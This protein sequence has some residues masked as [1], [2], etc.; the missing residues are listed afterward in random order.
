MGYIASIVNKKGEDTSDEM[1]MMLEVASKGDATSYGIANNM[2][3]ESFKECS[4]F[5]SISGHMLIGSKNLHLEEYP[6]EPLNQASH[7][8]VFKGIL[9]DSDNV[10]SLEVGNSIM[11]NPF[12]GVKEIISNREGAFSILVVTNDS[13]V[14]GLD[15]IGTIPLYY[16]ENSRSRAVATNKRMLWRIGIE[17]KPLHPGSILTL[18]KEGMKKSIVK[19][20]EYTPPS[21]IDE[22]TAIEGLDKALSETATQLT[23]KLRKGVVAFSGGVDSTII[24]QYLVWAGM[25]I[26]L[27][28]TGLEGQA[29]IDIAQKAAESLDLPIEVQTFTDHD[30]ENT[31]DDIIYSV[32]EPH[33]MKIGIAYP[34]HWTAKK[35]YTD[36]AGTVFSGNGADE[37]L[38]GYKRYHTSFINGEDVSKMIFTDVT[39]SWTN[40]F[41][42]DTK[43]CLDQGMRLILPFTHP[44][45]IN[46]GLSIH[47]SLNISTDEVCL[48]KL[49]LRKLAK[50]VGIP[51]EIADRPKK[52]AQYSTGVD[53][54]LR[55]LAKKIGFSTRELVMA[56]Y[57]DISRV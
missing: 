35:A 9:Y 55:R 29:E 21:I 15:H 45:V 49:V 1:L 30:V 47:P 53:K 17:P 40:N 7:S 51:V 36:G 39:D 52:A 16:G 10:D 20:L 44:K 50:K 12:E 13:I 32:E 26:K 42:R 57:L 24:A 23:R 18:S 43:T 6:P 8:Y 31:L 46:H 33:P 38:G 14:C 4:E 2:D 41:H 19:S 11:D 3:T 37:L 48:R 25:D 28:T 54:S 27:I 5:T 56:K 22:K 34:F